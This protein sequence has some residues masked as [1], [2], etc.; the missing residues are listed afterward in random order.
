[1]FYYHPNRHP[2]RVR[3]YLLHFIGRSHDVL[4]DVSIYAGNSETLYSVMPLILQC[5]RW[6]TLDLNLLL[7]EYGGFSVPEI[8]N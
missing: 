7:R 3:R 2:E 6:E 4:L 8:A 1:M 5:H